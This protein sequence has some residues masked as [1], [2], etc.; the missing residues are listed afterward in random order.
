MATNGP[1]WMPQAL[2]TCSLSLFVRIALPKMRLAWCYRFW[3]G[4]ISDEVTPEFLGVGVSTPLRAS[5]Q[6][7]ESQELT[8]FQLLHG[9]DFF[10][11]Q[12]ML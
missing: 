10:K 8:P 2:K 5:R 6:E 7:L 1:V 9:V 12:I 3:W 11:G 4:Q